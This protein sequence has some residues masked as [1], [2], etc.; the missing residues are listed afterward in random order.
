MSYQEIYRSLVKD[1]S[2]NNFDGNKVL[3][4]L[5][6]ISHLF[7]SY[8]FSNEPAIILRELCEGFSYLDTLYILPK[9]NEL[10]NLL[11]SLRNFEYELAYDEI[12]TEKHYGIKYIRL[13][14]D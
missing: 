4:V 1:T 2:F 11:S 14:W 10:G 3:E 8:I 12:S 5:D 6:S 9:D 7:E 13:W